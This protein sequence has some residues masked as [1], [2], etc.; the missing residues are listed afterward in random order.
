MESLLSLALDKWHGCFRAS[1]SPEIM[2]L[3]HYSKMYLSFHNLLSLPLMAG[4]RGMKSAPGSSN[5]LLISD[6]TIRAA[7]RVLDS[8]AARSRSPSVDCLCPIWLPIVVFHAG[9]VVWA[10]QNVSSA[11]HRAEYGSARILVAFKIE[12]D[13]MPWPCCVEMAASLGRLIAVSTPSQER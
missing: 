5:K 4:Y 12:L 8:A 2:A 10:H 11:Q 6:T 7:W 3:Y 1:T 13:G 9:L